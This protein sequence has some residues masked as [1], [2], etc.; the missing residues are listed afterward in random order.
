MN[1]SVLRCAGGR[2]PHGFC[3][4]LAIFDDGQ[5]IAFSLWQHVSEMESQEAVIGM[6]EEKDEPKVKKPLC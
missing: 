2:F 4:E 3:S 1:D 6:L 5:E